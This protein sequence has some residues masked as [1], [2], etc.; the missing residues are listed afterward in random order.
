[1][2]SEIYDLTF[3]YHQK[4]GHYLMFYQKQSE[5][6]TQEDIVAL[7][8]KMMQSNQIQNLLP[9]S[10]EEIDF[11]VRLYYDITSKQTL[12]QFLRERTLS[13]YDFYQLFI[14][15]LTTLEQS[16]LYMLNEHHYVL[17]EEFIFLGKDTQQLYLIYLPFQEIEKQTTTAAELKSL[18][19]NVAKKNGSLMEQEF[20]SLLQY[21]EDPSFSFSGLKELLL[22]LQ[23]RHPGA[24]HPLQQSEYSG[25]EAAEEQLADGTGSGAPPADINQPPIKTKGKKEKKQKKAEKAD[26]GAAKSVTQPA[27]LT[28]REKVYVVCIAL[29]LLTGLFKLFEWMPNGATLLGSVGAGSIIVVLTIFILVRGRWPFRKAPSTYG[30]PTEKKKSAAVAAKNQ[31]APSASP[32]AQVPKHATGNRAA[33]SQGGAKRTYPSYE[34]APR[35]QDVLLAPQQSSYQQ[36]SHHGGAA[37]QEPTPSPKAE[38]GMVQQNGGM[39]QPSGGMTQQN[40]HQEKNSG[41]FVVGNAPKEL[42]EP[43]VSATMMLSEEENATVLLGDDNEPL[44]TT[45][46]PPFLEIRRGEQVEK[47]VI[48]KD[49]FI[50]GRNQ[51]AVNYVEDSVGI[52]RI[53][54]ELAKVD[55]KWGLRDLGSKNGTKVNGHPLVP[56]KIYALNAD[57]LI[58]IGK[59]KYC[60]KQESG[61]P[62]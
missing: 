6:V 38:R 27:T 21:A 35:Q 60:F 33:V 39:N 17:K 47:I 44:L 41:Y 51:T 12:H 61:I 2:S 54:L 49:R 7:Q 19:L 52:S 13:S 25:H 57:D 15:I 32:V 50:I 22:Q 23:H 5:E 45:E 37:W 53:H 36:D 9:L 1:M 3:E 55:D 11:K 40:N 24:Y 29:L 56:H 26:K 8:L 43:E 18:L 58:A 62:K 10:V 30:K 46:P 20:R 16:K 28:S 4:N 14:K 59:V 34:P 42:S 31:P 48:D